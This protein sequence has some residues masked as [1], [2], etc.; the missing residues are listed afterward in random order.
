MTESNKRPE[1]PVLK[2]DGFQ[3]CEGKFSVSDIG[4]VDGSRLEQLFQPETLRL[5][6]EQKAARESAHTLF[7]KAFF[8]AQLKYY[9]VKFA[10][11]AKVSDLREL[12]E[13]AVRDGKCRRVPAPVIQIEKSMQRDYEPLHQAWKHDALAYDA[14]MKKQGDDN[15]AKCT[16]AG[17]RASLDLP[18]FM[19]YYFLTDGQPDRN[20][21]REPLAVRGFEDRAGLHSI[22]EPVQGLHTVSGGD[23]AHRTVCI[24]WDMDAVWSLAAGINAESAKIRK[25]EQDARRE[26]DMDDHREY[27][28]QLSQGK[29]SRGRKKKTAKGAK[30]SSFDIQ[31][32]RGS[33]IVHCDAVSDGWSQHSDETFT[34]DICSGKDRT[35]IA[36][37]QLGI[38]EGTMLLGL[39]EEQLDELAECDSNS[40]SSDY[41]DEDSEQEQNYKGKKRTVQ[42]AKPRAAKRSKA[43]TSPSRRVY[44]RLRGAETG[45]GEIFYDPELGHL[46]FS[47]DDCVRFDGVAD[48][49][50]CIGR[51]VKFQGFKISDTPQRRPAAWSSFSEKA[52]E[53]ARVGRWH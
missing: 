38:I 26:G 11:A 39:S 17:E 32:C 36:D 47:D 29:T 8:V 14:K 35:L 28:K 43:T 6:R 10:S 15:F 18:R 7:K 31:Q 52:Y 24:G 41:D 16:T 5:K 40:S 12:L 51:N 34:L 4:R 37:F 48:E 1:P 19:E 21:R 25:Q 46:D 9:G 49:L 50:L 20:K 53:K 33:Y 22:A 45:E 27:M 13:H 23:G 30:A 2:R 42:A 44:F 3:I